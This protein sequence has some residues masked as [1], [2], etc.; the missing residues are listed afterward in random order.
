M[1]GRGRRGVHRDAVEF[2]EE[3]FEAVE[4]G[5][6]GEQADAL[7]RIHDAGRVGRVRVVKRVELRGGG[8]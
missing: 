1:R 5:P 3:L 4:E 2:G 6:I 7:G 8:G